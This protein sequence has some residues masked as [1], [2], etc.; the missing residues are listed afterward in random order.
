[1]RKVGVTKAAVARFGK[2][3]V[4]TEFDNGA[5]EDIGEMAN[6]NFIVLL[7]S[8]CKVDDLAEWLFFF[9]AEFFFATGYR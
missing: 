8:A 5:I 7:P 1:M 2:S 9:V 6:Q 3:E 4:G